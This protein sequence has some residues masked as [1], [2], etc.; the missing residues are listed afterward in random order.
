[1]PINWVSVLLEDGEKEIISL[2]K[3]DDKSSMNYVSNLP[4]SFVLY[5][6]SN[7]RSDHSEES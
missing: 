2:I 7:K 5:I 6:I 3:F 4:F 1:M